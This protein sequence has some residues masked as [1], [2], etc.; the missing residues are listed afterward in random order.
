MAH[1]VKTLA[2]KPEDLSSVPKIHIVKGKD[3]FLQ[4]LFLPPH[5]CYKTYTHTH[6]YTCKQIISKKEFRASERPS[7]YNRQRKLNQIPCAAIRCHVSG[8][9]LMT[10]KYAQHMH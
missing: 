8:E 7:K 9:L 2:S 3:Q 6:I 1:V 5:T 10:W 4:V